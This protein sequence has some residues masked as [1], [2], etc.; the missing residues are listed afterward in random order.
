[1]PFVPKQ[2]DL[3]SNNPLPTPPTAVNTFTN[4]SSQVQVPTYVPLPVQI[5]SGQVT[6]LIYNNCTLH[7]S[8]DAT[9]YHL[10]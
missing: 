8:D 10:Q 2:K 7:F 5:P 6:K 1:M 3:N 4:L 9:K